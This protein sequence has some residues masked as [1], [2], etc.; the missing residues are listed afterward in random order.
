MEAVR[1][2]NRCAISKPLSEFRCRNGYYMRRCKKCD[3]AKTMEYR[4]S[5]A[6]YGED[7]KR[8][9]KENSTRAKERVIG[10]YGGM[11]ACCGETDLR[12]LTLDHKDG[13]GRRVRKE[14]GNMARGSRYYRWLHTNNYPED[15][16]VL[17]FNC[18]CGRQVN[19]GVCPHKD[20]Y[21]GGE[22]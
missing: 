12:F 18:N 10:H 1:T 19:G 9:Q 2:C 16:Q 20:N 6:K 14:I 7:T 13:G 15:L 21:Q 8:V 3:S 22:K 5:N 17:C 4:H 11:C